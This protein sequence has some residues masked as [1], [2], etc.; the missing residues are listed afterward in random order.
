MIFST[1]TDTAR[2]ILGDVKVWRTKTPESGRGEAGFWPPA[3][4]LWCALHDWLEHS[5]RRGTYRRSREGSVGSKDQ[6]GLGFGLS[7]FGNGNNRKQK[8]ETYITI[9]KES[10]QK[11]ANFWTLNLLCEPSDCFWNYSATF[12][13]CSVSGPVPGLGPWVPPGEPR[14]SP[15]GTPWCSVPTDHCGGGEQEKTGAKR[16]RE[17]MPQSACP[18]V[19]V[20]GRGR[21][22]AQIKS[23]GLASRAKKI[24][25]MIMCFCRVL[26]K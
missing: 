23:N 25:N 26:K 1:A 22:W 11:T 4:E 16:E 19:C 15:V 9:R 21:I 5:S 14:G 24:T 7:Q 18:P 2:T 6:F 20:S 13:E 3:S 8:I 17:R 10:L 12:W